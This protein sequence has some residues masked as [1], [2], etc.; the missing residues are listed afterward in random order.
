[1]YY[2]NHKIISQSYQRYRKEKKRE[3]QLWGEK[4]DLQILRPSYTLI[5]K[6]GQARIILK[7]TIYD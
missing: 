4:L 5:E 3:V 2:T 1:M 7:K 6:T